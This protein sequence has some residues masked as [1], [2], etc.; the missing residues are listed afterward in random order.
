MKIPTLHGKLVE[1][2]S[3]LT[4]AEEVDNHCHSFP[5]FSVE[6]YTRYKSLEC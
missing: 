5:I 6:C 3:D 2:D 4:I 1:G